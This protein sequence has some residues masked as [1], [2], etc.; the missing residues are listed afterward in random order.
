MI[1]VLAA[2]V[3][4]VSVAAA[5]AQEA[6]NAPG[7][8]LRGL[9][10][11]AGRTQDISIDVGETIQYGRLNITVH[12]CRYLPENPAG[13]AFALLT[14]SSAASGKLFFE[15]WM[16]SSSPALSSMDHQRYDV[17]LIRCRTSDPGEA[18]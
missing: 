12:D 4:A 8:L 18:G 11:I 5:M 6:V 3:A 10:T 9:D 16:L 17:W 7:A 15:G 13:N 14:I 2:A 1:A